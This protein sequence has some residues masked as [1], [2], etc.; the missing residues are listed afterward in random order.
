M[1]DKIKT[2]KLWLIT[3]LNHPQVSIWKNPSDTPSR[4]I[5]VI[6]KT[7]EG[8]VT[9]CYSWIDGYFIIE[10]GTFKKVDC[11]MWTEV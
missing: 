4:M 7:P 1:K 11:I 2:F 3:R 6:I 8:I 10:H 5:N 9:G